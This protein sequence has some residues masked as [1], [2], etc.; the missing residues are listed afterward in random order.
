VG[1]KCTDTQTYSLGH[2]G[3]AVKSTVIVDIPEVFISKDGTKGMRA[4]L[5]ECSYN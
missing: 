3:E 4:V 1:P 2:T 5:K